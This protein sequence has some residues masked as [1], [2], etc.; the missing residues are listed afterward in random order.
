LRH[1][2]FGRRRSLSTAATLFPGPK[3]FLL[4]VLFVSHV[5]NAESAAASPWSCR[6]DGEGVAKHDQ[7]NHSFDQQRDSFFVLWLL[8]NPF[9]E[10]P[11]MSQHNN[12][13]TAQQNS[14]SAK[15]TEHS[16]NPEQ[17]LRQAAHILANG[18][19]RAA[20]KRRAQQ[21]DDEQ[22][23]AKQETNGQQYK[24]TKVREPKDDH[25]QTALIADV[26]KPDIPPICDVE[27]QDIGALPTAEIALDTPLGP[28]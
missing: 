26:S 8:M 3:A 21:A 22:E 7:R 16:S 25:L 9:M 10:L 14:P 18:A 6:C 1:L 27:S 13:T 5:F 11:I 24:R 17:R 28:L 23:K 4:S 2:L 12:T 15:T 20:L 19:I